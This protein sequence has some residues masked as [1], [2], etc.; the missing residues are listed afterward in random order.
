M[1][2]QVNSCVCK[3]W[4]QGW[5]QKAKRAEKEHQILLLES[6]SGLGSAFW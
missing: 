5:A 2:L 6:H 3:C 4:L 1:P